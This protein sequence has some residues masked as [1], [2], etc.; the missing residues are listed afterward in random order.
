ME[1]KP[2]FGNI[3]DVAINVVRLGYVRALLR[4]TGTHP[5]EL[6]ED[7]LANL[8]K[9]FESSIRQDRDVLLECMK[10]AYSMGLNSTEQT[11]ITGGFILK[12]NGKK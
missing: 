9:P 10:V 4:G 1:S 8:V 12:G 11:P 7:E 2:P 5:F 6:S 3:V